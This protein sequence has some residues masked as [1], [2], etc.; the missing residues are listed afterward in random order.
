MV[1]CSWNQILQ[2]TSG[3]HGKVR[4]LD[5]HFQQIMYVI[6]TEETSVKLV[7]EEWQTV[8]FDRHTHSYAIPQH[9]TPS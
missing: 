2:E 3:N 5:A 8:T 7:T 9:S 4:R 1:H 6:V